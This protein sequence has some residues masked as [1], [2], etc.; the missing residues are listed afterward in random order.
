MAADWTPHSGLV[1]P[2][3]MMLSCTQSCRPGGPPPVTAARGARAG[4]LLR[5][6]ALLAFLAASMGCAER[7]AAMICAADAVNVSGAPLSDVRIVHEPTGRFFAV[8]TLLPG[9]SFF[10][11]FRERELAAQSAVVSWTDAAGRQHEE[12]LDIDGFGLAASGRPLRI[13]YVIRNGGGA[14]VEVR[15]CSA[16]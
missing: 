3:R 14:A 8:G 16:Q 9:R 2:F 1:Y 4:L 11:D 13:V 10:L 6:A 7:R 15:P 5:A 12:R